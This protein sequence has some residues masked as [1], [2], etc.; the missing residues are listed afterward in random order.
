MLTRPRRQRATFRV[1][2]AQPHQPDV[3]RDQADE[4]WRAYPDTILEFGSPP[5]PPLRIDLRERL[6][7]DARSRLAALG[8]ATAFGVFTAENPAGE[9]AEDEATPDEEAREE[10]RNVHREGRL[11]REL[12][13]RGAPFVR[14]D[15]V[16]PDGSYRE[17]CVAT[18]VARD[19]AVALARRFEQLALFWYDGSA[20]W[21]LPALAEKAPQR[22]PVE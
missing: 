18:L 10:R 21:L 7:D 17:H 3:N 16:S 12:R 9:N 14:V 2:H 8:L 22:L 15:G 13:E 11:E 4:K 5:A 6:G 20:F 1:T 19:E